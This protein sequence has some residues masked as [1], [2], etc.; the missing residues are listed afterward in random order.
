MYC[1]VFESVRGSGRCRR[2]GDDYRIAA[3]RVLG[4]SLPCPKTYDLKAI[5]SLLARPSWTLGFPNPKGRESATPFPRGCVT[6]LLRD[7]AH[8]AVP[9]LFAQE[10]DARY[11]PPPKGSR[12]P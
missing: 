4:G 3:L 2:I 10:I 6:S 1:C 7:M 9:C 11:V 12:V 5:S 8:Q